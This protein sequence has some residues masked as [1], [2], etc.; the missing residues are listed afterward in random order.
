MSYA[1]EKLYRRRKKVR[2]LLSPIPDVL[3]ILLAFEITDPAQHPSISDGLAVKSFRPCPFHLNSVTVCTDSPEKTLSSTSSATRGEDVD[4]DGD[5][6]S[7]ASARRGDDGGDDDDDD[8]SG[9]SVQTVT[10][11]R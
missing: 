3:H 2:N 5:G 1:A 11:F 4:K 10:E 7:D 6:P 8:F 9:E